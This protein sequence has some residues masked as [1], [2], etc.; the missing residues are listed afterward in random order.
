MNILIIEDERPN[1]ERLKRLILGIK[2][3]ANILSVLESVSESVEWL[4]SHEKPDLIMMDI[5][6]SDGLSFE[7][8]DKTQLVD[9]PIIFT[10]AYDEYAIKAFKQYSI[11][12]LLKPVDKDE[13]AMAFEKYDQLDIMVNKATNPSIEKLLDEFRSKN[14]RT[15]FL[16]SYRDGFKTV[17]VSDV[18]YFYSEQKITKARLTDGTDEIIP[19]TMDELEQQLDPKLF[20]RANRQFIICINA[21]EHVYNYFN[22]KLKVTMR[23]NTDVE[24]IVSRDKA[25]LLKNWMGY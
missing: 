3:Q 22:N 8:F 23:K 6:L 11:D 15:R 16:L 13:L 14:Y 7:I 18:L 2:P 12:Y 4:D 9:V 20:F 25:P 19:H 17:M 1:A 24:I 10:T 21:V 5:K